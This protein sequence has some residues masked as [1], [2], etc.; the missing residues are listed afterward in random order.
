MK[1]YSFVRF[2]AFVAAALSALTICSSAAPTVS[3]DVESAVDLE[4]AQNSKA[5][6]AD[7]FLELP[8]S[9]LELPLSK[10][11]Q[12]ELLAQTENDASLFASAFEGSGTK[13]SPY[14]IKSKGDLRLFATSIRS[15]S[16][17]YI[18]ACYK[19]T[20]D[21]DLEG[22]HWT[23][24]GMYSSSEDP[25]ATAFAGVFDGDGHT[26]KNFRI[27]ADT[28][29]LGFFGLT[30][31]ASI[32]DLTIS[33]FSLE[34]DSSAARP[35]YVGGLVG[36]FL[37]VG[38]TG[39]ETEC[40]IE[41]CH[42][43]N[44]SI[45]ITGSKYSV[46]AG[47]LAGSLH[48][49][50]G[51]S[52]T[53]TASDSTADVSA[54][55]TGYAAEALSSATFNVY[56]GGLVGYVGA[57]K[58]GATTGGTIL[59]QNAYSTGRVQAT[60]TLDNGRASKDNL[61]AG[62][63]IGYLGSA[64]GSSVTVEACYSL[65]TVTSKAVAEN[66]SGSFLGYMIANNASSAVVRN[67]YTASGVY[68]QSS[69]YDSYLSGFTSIAGE[70]KDSTFRIEKCY[71]AGLVVD[72][73]TSD[74]S[75]G[76]SMAAYALGNTSFTD[77]YAHESALVACQNLIDTTSAPATVLSDENA[78]SLASYTG[79]STDVW[80][81]GGTTYAFP[82]LKDTKHIDIPL[83]VTFMNTSG[84]FE[85][86]KDKQF[87]D[88][89][90]FPETTPGSNYV[91]SHWSLAPG[92]DAVENYAL[93]CDTRFY[94][95]FSDTLRS[96][97][98]TF[99]A[100]GEA[101]HTADLVYGTAVAF[102]SPPEKTAD[103]I[104]RYVFSH[105]S[106]T[107]NG[108]D[109]CKDAL[110]SGK[111]TYYAVYEQIA[112]GSWDGVTAAAF[113]EGDGTAE[114]PYQIKDAYN[115]FYLSKNVSSETYSK[116]NYVLTRDIDL[117]GFA[118][119]PIGTEEAPFSGVFDGAGYSITGLKLTTV[120]T[121]VGLFGYTDG[122]TIRKLALYDFTVQITDTTLPEMY[123]GVLVG[124]FRAHGKNAV[125]EI[126]ECSVTGDL[127]VQTPIA[128]V[129]GVSGKTSAGQGAF[130]YIEDSFFDGTIK[131]T[132]VDSAFVGGIT[133]HYTGT[134]LG[135]SGIDRCYASVDITA[136]VTKTNSQ[137]TSVGASYAGGIVGYLAD[138][139][140]YIELEEDATYLLASETGTARNCFA[141]GSITIT[142]SRYSNSSGHIYGQMNQSASISNCAADK[143]MTFET[144][145]T[146][147]K[148][149]NI[150]LI[151]DATQLYTA[152]FLQSLG[153]DTEAVWR[154][155]ENALPLLQFED[156][157][158]NV[159]RVK[160]FEY[161][162]NTGA[163]TASFLISYRDVAGYSILA[164]SYDVRDKMIG[165]TIHKIDD[166]S[167]LQTVS[168]SLP[169]VKGAVACRVSVIDSKSF[170]LLEE[171]MVLT[172]AD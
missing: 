161:N 115:L 68:A 148:N 134:S 89:V 80:E 135:V 41:N 128:Y 126:A 38:Q 85:T 36:R 10:D 154:V 73:A 172:S 22:E 144:I 53:V 17:T 24:V 147:S 44:A 42:I 3:F 169:S 9:A 152:E 113:E 108:T 23:P 74:N 158:K 77:C 71:T 8:E 72:T 70:Q 157:T 167:N 120:H 14:L 27:A 156:M 18:N 164:A 143:N 132:A 78:T 141:R 30:Y 79:F 75:Y 13:E 33:D 97:T 122:A 160:S 170:A 83:I 52:I 129:G 19:L 81:N 65:G 94:P 123:V 88:S 91:F 92:G 55:L 150:T 15:G 136:N 60:A 95:N 29:H 32:C 110:V 28:R 116:A 131:V 140:A 111:A 103:Q 117:G 159:Y 149:A 35:F 119:T 69:K 124:R 105:W 45:D 163:L 166:P 142:A 96:F 171:P 106:T 109:D 162:K 133:G 121:D 93:R 34:L 4:V 20:A 99:V 153:F 61:K 16:S 62:G 151:E 50:D 82:T 43:Q 54:A 63:F 31:N 48:A 114:N 98:I 21:I 168:V 107:E 6:L 64:L 49:S 138:D 127:F 165:F 57:T 12:K 40:T 145:G 139:E 51:A 39:T 102:P 1:K 58:E 87:G 5:L 59:L 7:T 37:A 155:R 101:F 11:E 67:C 46:Y 104:Y 66:Y 86:Q 90:T 76:G 100:D 125:A 47:G 137:G 146:V 84:V 2:G 25:Y 130:V 56:A 118:W 26:V 112:I